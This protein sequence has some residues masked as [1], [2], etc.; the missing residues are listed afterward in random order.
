MNTVKENKKLEF[1]GY[2]LAE[3]ETGL[4]RGTLYS[5]VCK[6]QIPHTRLGRRLVRFSRTVL[7]EWM[8]SNEITLEATPV[9]HEDRTKS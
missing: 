8:S 2:A 9:T 7:R 5:M 6:K 4:N 3:E 1:G